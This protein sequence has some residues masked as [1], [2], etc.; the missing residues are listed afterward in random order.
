M[1][2]TFLLL[3]LIFL[4]SSQSA[5][6]DPPSPPQQ[7]PDEVVSRDNAVP[8]VKDG[9][10]YIFPGEKFGVNAEVD[11]DKIA[12]LRYVKDAAKADIQLEFTKRKGGNGVMMLLVIENKLKQTLYLD[13][14]MQVPDRKGAYKTSILPVLAGKGGFESWPHTISLLI[15]RN[16]RFTK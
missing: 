1:P 5:G 9:S 16:L 7:N 2:R 11:G 4:Q 15:L 3:I 8:Y 14:G 13:A 6:Q 12:S 10:I